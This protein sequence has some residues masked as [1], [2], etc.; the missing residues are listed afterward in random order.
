[1]KYSLLPLPLL[2]VCSILAS[3]GSAG[4]QGGIRPQQ[5]WEY[6]E[7]STNPALKNLS[8]GVVHSA[9]TKKSLA[10]LEGYI[11]YSDRYDPRQLFQP[12]NDVLKRSFSSMSRFESVAEALDAG[13]DTAIVLDVKYEKG[14]GSGQYEGLA[15]NAAFFGR[16]KR[17][18][19][20]IETESR[21]RL[22]WPPR[23]MIPQVSRDVV[24]AFAAGLATAPGLAQ[25]AEAP[26]PGVA[27]AA[28]A[29]PA[30][31]AAPAAA[32]ATVPAVRA[33]RSNVDYPSYRLAENA[34]K[35]ALVIGVEAY[36][37]VV[38]APHA[39]R[40]AVAVKRHL[41]A[42]GYPERNV[43]LLADQ[44]AGKSAFEKYLEA[45]LPANTDERSSVFVYFSGHGAPSPANGQ[46]YLVPWDGD[47][48]FIDTTG[49]SVKRLYE[50]L[51]AL[52]ARKILVAM[53]ACFSGAGGRS[54]IAAGTRPLVGKLDL[55]SAAS[56]RVGALSASAADETS[57]TME[58]TGHGLF[59]FHLLKSL[60]VAGG[61]ATLSELANAL[62]PKVRD[63]ARREN[64]DQ[65]PQLIGDGSLSF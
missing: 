18:I 20:V 22:S 44:K 2:I 41:L 8:V 25:Y 5:Q 26:R 62:S 46:A 42:M 17:Q 15:L 33:F 23:S 45:W 19:A 30:S 14:E 24:A 32:P 27:S 29:S 40:D 7:P 43:I 52:K 6:S 1:M 53:D 50:K 54:V 16:D 10:E 9:A 57:G 4:G 11:R 59:T 61:R 21:K 37:D 55:G 39:V 47:P 36:S 48:K 60:Q 49:Y 63:A 12:L 13:F 65:T 58:E 35:F 51:N 64:R 3:C 28:P 31:S 38:A 56:G 34:N